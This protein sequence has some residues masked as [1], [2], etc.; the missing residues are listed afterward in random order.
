[1]SKMAAFALLGLIGTVGCAEDELAQDHMMQEEPAKIVFGPVDGLN[2][3]GVDL[4]R[5]QKGQMSPD[6]TLA[7]LAGSP[8]TLSDFRGKKNVVLVFYRGHW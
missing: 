8:V 3:P 5:V 7:S 1:M 6:F 2:L 4:E